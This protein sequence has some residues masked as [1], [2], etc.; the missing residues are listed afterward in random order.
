MTK[1]QKIGGFNLACKWKRQIGEMAPKEKWFILTNLDNL[2]S[3]PA[4]KKDLRLKKCFEILRVV[5]R[6][7]R[8]LMLQ[9]SV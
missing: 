8:I 4:T 9:V 5:A 6:I 3:A 2:K 1:T 7:W